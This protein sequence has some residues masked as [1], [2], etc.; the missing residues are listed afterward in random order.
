MND[1]KNM[2]R[3][4]FCLLFL[5]CN[6]STDPINIIKSSLQS[7][8]GIQKWESIK[9]ITYRKTTVLYDSVGNIEN[10]MIQTHKNRLYPTFSAEIKWI[11]DSIQKRAV[12]KNDEVSVFFNNELQANPQ[13]EQNYYNAIIA[14]NYVFWQPYK[15]LKEDV[16]LSYNGKEV[17]DGASVNV[18]RA[19]YV[20]KDGS[21]ANTWW[22]YFDEKT[23]KLIGNMVYHAPTYSFIKNIKYENKTGLFLNAE[24]K[25]YR[26]DSL[27]NVQFLRAE[28]VY[29][30]LEFN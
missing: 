18:I 17:I 30:I 24:R 5:G 8:G 16:T 19:N 7:H 14:G 1:L 11:E 21:P 12:L 4:G 25:S 27:R 9:E 15:L 2:L 3:L 22:Y 6:N 26:V 10:K 29:E 20:Y 13:L 23:N 28:Y